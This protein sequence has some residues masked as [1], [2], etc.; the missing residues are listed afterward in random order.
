MEAK[1]KLKRLAITSALTAVSA[2]AAFSSSASA[3][4][5]TMTYTG[6]VSSVDYT[7]TTPSGQTFTNSPTDAL[8]FFGGGNLA[9]DNFTVQ[10]TFNASAGT[11]SATSG[12]SGDGVFSPTVFTINNI[13]QSLVQSPFDS[14]TGASTNGGGVGDQLQN[15]IFAQIGG[16]GTNFGIGTT[17]NATP[18]A[19]V[20]FATTNTITTSCGNGCG[21]FGTF[22]V[23]GEDIVFTVAQETTVDTTTGMTSAVPEPSTWAMM[24]LGFCG[25]GFMAYRR[26]QNGVALSVA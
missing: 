15:G 19:P 17:I 4:V 23:G 14:A 8:N 1:L 9:G 26:K 2:L 5:I 25:L 21:G 7:G 11:G 12:G 13:S 24:I 3:D 10:F 20:T 18:V 16:A 6:T 22:N